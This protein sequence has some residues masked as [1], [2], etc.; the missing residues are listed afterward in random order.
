MGLVYL[1]SSPDDDVVALKLIR[2]ELADDQDFRRRFKSEV[3]AV[4]RVDGICT[5]KVRDADVDADRPWVVT[6]FVAGPNLA[7]LVDRNGPLPRDQQRALALGL[8][9]ALV[10]IHRAG[11]VHRDL[12][13]T[14]VLCSPSGPKVID[15]GIA[16]T[17][18]ATTVTLTGEVIGSPSWMSPEQVGG[19]AATTGADMFSLG[20]VLV[21]AATGRPPFGKGQLEGVMWR[22]L[23]EPADLGGV[24]LL[25]AGL[26]PLVVRMLEKD[27]A[28]RPNAREVLDQLSGRE[29]D[30]ARTVTQ[31]LHRSWVLPAAEVIRVGGSRNHQALV[32]A[33]VTPGDFP[34]SVRRAGWYA[35]P[36]GNG[37]LRWWDGV[38]WTDDVAD[39]PA[40]DSV[41]LAPPGSD[42]TGDRPDGRPATP[43]RFGKSFFVG[44]GLLVTVA[45]AA[46]IWGLDL[47]AGGSNPR[48]ASGTTIASTGRSPAAASSLT[49]PSPTQVQRPSQAPASASLA[50][51]RQLAAH[52][53]PPPADYT[54]GPG[55]MYPNGLITTTEYDQQGGAGSSASIGL[56]GG[57]EA[58]YTDPSGDFIN[59][60]LL[61]FSSPQSAGSSE[62]PMSGLLPAESPRQSAFP[63]I[64]GA[65]A[66]NGTKP[67]YG[68]YHHELAATKGPV[69]MVFVC[70]TPTGA[71]LP[72]GLAAWAEQQYAHV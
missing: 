39:T 56:L 38:D 44:V 5:A 35:D 24:G 32:E 6:D 48:H 34:V 37:G 26:R 47:N 36:L 21:F 29:Q 52:L 63:G 2:P 10:A 60:Q 7:D 69:L 11:I 31:V 61:R 16:Q 3:A 49:S 28:K 72:A 17:A 23:N 59:V 68:M 40:A 53:I 45:T 54:G 33:A 20:A 65:I 22:I 64:P 18:D 42:R 70:S 57:F 27:P 51:S 13:P 8:T 66:V 50:V 43:H 1:A 14:N 62:G 41:S 30:A 67:A 19:G 15:F 71:P 25:D 9:E 12:K 55:G 4:Q 46:A 58:T